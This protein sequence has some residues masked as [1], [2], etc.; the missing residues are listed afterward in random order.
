M[1]FLQCLLLSSIGIWVAVA[2]VGLV[3][4]ILAIMACA[5]WKCYYC[6][7]NPLVDCLEVFYKQL[8]T[9]FSFLAK[10][11]VTMLFYASLLVTTIVFTFVCCICFAFLQEWPWERAYREVSEKFHRSEQPAC[12]HRENAVHSDG[13]D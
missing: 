13:S 7:A 11:F 4:T 8:R 10:K 1:V 2:V 6:L 5:K 9:F 12:C 3:C